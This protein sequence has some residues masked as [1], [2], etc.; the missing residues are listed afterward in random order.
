MQTRA[1]NTLADAK[2]D[3]SKA[4]RAVCAVFVVG[5]MTT[6]L[7]LPTLAEQPDRRQQMLDAA[8]RFEPAIQR[9]DD[10][11]RVV[12]TAA[13]DAITRTPA[14]RMAVERWLTRRGAVV[15]DRAQPGLDLHFHA[16]GI[17]AMTPVDLIWEGRPKRAKS[18]QHLVDTLITRCRETRQPIGHLII[19]GHAGLPGCCALGETLDDCVFRGILTGYQKRQLNRLRPYFA[20]DAQIELRQCTAGKGK[21][22][23][24]LLKTLHRVTGAAA[25]SYE[26]DF[27]FGMSS[28]HP[29]IIADDKGV[30]LIEPGQ[31]NKNQ[32]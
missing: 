12:R 25:S 23:I 17:Q 31:G 26:G 15:L 9:L 4:L 1:H 10:E 7:A 32:K 14:Q 27:Y 24:L 19:V 29:R 20:N 2:N 3:P 11:R 6:L 5:L 13:L 8:A 28:S 21:E 30:R 22:G 16:D 18:L